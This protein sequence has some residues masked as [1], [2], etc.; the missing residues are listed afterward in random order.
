MGTVYQ[1]IRSDGQF[2]QTVAIKLV[3]RGMDNEFNLGRFRAERQILANLSHPNI[4]ALLDGGSTEDGSPYFVMEFIEGQPLVTYCRTQ[5]PSLAR[6]LELFQ[7]ICA[8]VH[9][10]HQAKVIRRDLKPGNI[11]ITTNGTPKLLDFRIAKILMP[12]TMAA[13][14]TE[15]HTAVR[16]LTPNYA[17]PEQVRGQP[18]SAATDI[19]LLG[20]LLYELVAGE[21]PF[22]IDGRSR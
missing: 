5:T 17:S 10:A 19:Y 20:L 22:R 1:A 21:H 12:D 6:R 8:A 11:L 13:D 4:A 18:V 16:M 2:F 3:R 9:Y 14:L 7:Q 15:T